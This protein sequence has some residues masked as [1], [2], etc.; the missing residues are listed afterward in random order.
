MGVSHLNVET[1]LEIE[2]INVHA[3]RIEVR[4]VNGPR[5]VID[6]SDDLIMV[7]MGVGDEHVLYISGARITLLRMLGDESDSDGGVVGHGYIIHPLQ[8][9]AI[10]LILMTKRYVSQ[11][12][13][14]L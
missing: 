9:N 6:E 1:V 8:P 14:R 4:M 3:D 10:Y 11:G 7:R 12:P 5:S 2:G 13:G